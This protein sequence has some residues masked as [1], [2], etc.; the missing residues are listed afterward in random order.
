MAT[1]PKP[2]PELTP[3]A[4][5][6]IQR[7]MLGIAL[8]SAAV[9]SVIS[10]VVGFGLD[11]IA[12]DD[13]YTKAYGEVSTKITDLV[14]AA[15]GSKTEASL[16]VKDIRKDAASINEL[17]ANLKKQSIDVDSYLNTNLDKIAS[18]LASKEEFRDKLVK[19]SQSD[20]AQLK[21][22]LNTLRSSI[23]VW[24][25]APPQFGVEGGVSECPVNT[26]AVGFAF[27]S[28]AG[29]AHGALWAGHVIC[30]PL[31]TGLR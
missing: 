27:Q 4:K 11:R 25:S 31:N 15:S 18:L 30:R 23:A 9:L 20:I 6:A 29:L 3:E 21:I 10:V 2:E 24:S 26:Y 8:P 13:A 22:D 14:T 16:I 7:Y 5:L 1:E 17:S 28:E 12:R 19:V